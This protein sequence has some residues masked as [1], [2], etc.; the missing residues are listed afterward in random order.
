VAIEN[1]LK[2]SE[3][4]E[5][6][7]VFANLGNCYM[8]KGV[9]A[10]AIYY[11]RKSQKLNPSDKDVAYNL[12]LAKEQTVDQI[13]IAGESGLSNWWKRNLT[14]AGIDNI[15]I[16]SILLA[17]LTLLAFAL[18]LMGRKTSLRKIGFYLG[19]ICFTVSLIS[20]FS[21]FT[22]KNDLFSQN[23]GIVM[24]GKL[25]VKSEPNDAA[26]DV[27]ILHEGTEVLIYKS[28]ENWFNISLGDDRVGWVETSSLRRF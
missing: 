13:E 6:A 7:E 23:R 11:F 4:F 5:S 21:T 25:N 22:A 10:E 27:F 8:K 28:N 17:F 14:L 12:D 19:L 20:L 3:E 1:Y 26:L 15:A 2:I 16:F 9:T 18:Y 24:K